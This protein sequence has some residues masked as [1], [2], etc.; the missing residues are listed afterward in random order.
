MWILNESVPVLVPLQ[1]KLLV[2]NLVCLFRVFNTSK[3]IIITVS[4]DACYLNVPA[5]QISCQEL[6][7]IEEIGCILGKYICGTHIGN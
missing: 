1:V 4:K 2:K 6:M 7:Q 5:D 3:T